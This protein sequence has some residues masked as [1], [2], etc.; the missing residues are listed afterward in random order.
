MAR[1]SRK[2]EEEMCEAGNPVAPESLLVPAI[3]PPTTTDTPHFSP[4]TYKSVDIVDVALKFE[5]L[6]DMRKKELIAVAM[7]TLS[8]V[9]NQVSWELIRSNCS[10]V[11]FR[12]L[13][14]CL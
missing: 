3:V 12:N 5:S 13:G 14:F 9:F 11:D 7:S 1:L 6:H 8:T 4:S 10:R 2:A